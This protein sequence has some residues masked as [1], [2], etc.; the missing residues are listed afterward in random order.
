MTRDEFQALYERGP[1]T[2]FAFVESLLQRLDI[3]T[4]RVQELE[5]RLGK[6]SHNSSNPPPAMD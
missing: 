1:D 6:D 4:A 3:L 2:T 5:N